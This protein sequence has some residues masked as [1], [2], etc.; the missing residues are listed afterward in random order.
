MGG[1]ARGFKDLGVITHYEH[2]RPY[3]VDDLLPYD[4]VVSYDHSGWQATS[5]ALHIWQRSGVPHVQW[6]CDNPYNVADPISDNLS[7]FRSLKRYSTFDMILSDD[8][9]ITR[10]LRK[11]GIPADYVPEGTDLDTFKPMPEIKPEFD[12]LIAGTPN[13]ARLKLIDFCLSLKLDIRVYGIWEGDYGWERQEEK[14]KALWKGAIDDPRE[15]NEV[16]CRAKILLDHSSP[17]DPDSC[18]GTV[19]NGMA[20]GC[21]LLTDYKPSFRKHFGTNEWT[22]RSEKHLKEMFVKFLG[23]GEERLGEAR[24]QRERTLPHSYRNRAELMLKM[25]RGRWERKP[26]GAIPEPTT[27]WKVCQEVP[28]TDTHLILQGNVD[29]KMNGLISETA[30]V[31]RNPVWRGQLKAVPDDRNA[32][33][34]IWARNV[35]SNRKFIGYYHKQQWWKGALGE[36]D[37]WYVVASGPSLKTLAPK[38]MKIKTGSILAVNAACKFIP[39]EKMDVCMA[40]DAKAPSHWWT[41]KDFSKTLCYASVY[42]NPE[43][44]KQRW[45]GIHWFSGLD[46]S[47]INSTVHE[48]YPYLLRLME[49]GSVSVTAVD[50][51]YQMKAKTIVLVGHDGCYEKDRLHVD[52]FGDLGKVLVLDAKDM[53]GETV[54]TDPTYWHINRT[55]RGVLFFLMKYAGVRIINATGRGILFGSFENG[56]YQI[57]CKDLDETIEEMEG[58][59]ST[60]DKRRFEFINV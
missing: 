60:P 19:F 55:M 17:Q 33:H 16:F 14:Y 31:T 40:M 44:T 24:R 11:D 59:V 28:G 54:Q 50:L 42:V 43:I 58:G 22:Y 52:T 3:D 13:P 39:T 37:V 9:K 41:G 12:V 49:G 21:L 10:R 27:S 35:D 30:L 45:K 48:K 25:I 57:E 7:C 34:D 18:T 5:N 38:L 53:H 56:R 4:F 26:E 8:E 1:L 2:V 32:K 51:A 46:R 47:F 36:N 20:S 29:V 23:H 15:L 6:W